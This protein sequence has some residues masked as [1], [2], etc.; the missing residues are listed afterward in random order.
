[1]PGRGRHQARSLASWQ[2]QLR[3]AK[4][5]SR[6]RSQRGFLAAACSWASAPLAHGG[7]GGQQAWPG[8]GPVTAPAG[9]CPSGDL[10]PGRGPAQR[11]P[12]RH[13]PSTRP[14]DR[15]PRAR[16]GV[17]ARLGAAAR[18][19]PWPAAAGAHTGRTRDMPRG[20]PCREPRGPGPTAH[21]GSRRLS[22]VFYW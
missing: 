21:T 6:T 19:W 2:C 4:L 22:W 15:A 9:R 10:T 17:A 13:W 16:L 3:L 7:P 14:V 12:P 20:A 8:L 11:G 1:M 18:P 5:P